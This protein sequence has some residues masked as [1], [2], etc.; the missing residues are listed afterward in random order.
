MESP[1][2]A[3]LRWLGWH[4]GDD[5]AGYSALGNG[6]VSHFLARGRRAQPGPL[7]PDVALAVF[8]FW[9]AA[10]RLAVSLGR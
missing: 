4:N 5:L 2:A 1:A 10:L 7:D 3:L 6:P 9:I 8:R